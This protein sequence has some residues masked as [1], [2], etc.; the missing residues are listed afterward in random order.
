MPPHKVTVVKPWG[1]YDSLT[2]NEKT[3]VKIITVQPGESLSLQTHA[4][5]SEWWIVLD[6]SLD[7]VIN[8]TTATL[9]Q[10]QDIFI[11]AG[12]PHRVSGRDKPCRWLEIAYGLFAEA[13]IVR[14]QDKYGRV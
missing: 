5:R 13:D 7:I 8:D 9:A 12:T 1:R 4:H 14:L 2:L 11:P 10:G 6:A 3:T